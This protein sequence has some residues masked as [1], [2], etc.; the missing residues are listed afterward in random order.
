MLNKVLHNTNKT[1]W[2]EIWNLEQFKNYE[3]Y[4]FLLWWKR[5][6]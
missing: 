2:V 4:Q 6:I 5:F 3:D 1:G